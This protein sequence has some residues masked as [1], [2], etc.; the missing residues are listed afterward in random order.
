MD[1]Q[2]LFWELAAPML[3]DPAVSRSTMMVLPCCREWVAVPIPGA[4]VWEALLEEVG[5]LV[6]GSV[7]A[8]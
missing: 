5:G 2:E 3:A 1:S 8:P 7:G 4:A 6:A